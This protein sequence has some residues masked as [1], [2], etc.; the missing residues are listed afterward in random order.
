MPN[1]RRA[2]E[3]EMELQELS[4]TIQDAVDRTQRTPARQTDS[5]SLADLTQALQGL[6]SQST[7]SIKPPQYSGSGDLELFLSQFADIAKVN[8][9]SPEEHLLHFRLSLTKLLTVAGATPYQKFKT[10]CAYG[11]D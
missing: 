9:W 1:R 8:K 7:P 4:S 5:I 6:K 2:R 3:Q 11:L 10:C